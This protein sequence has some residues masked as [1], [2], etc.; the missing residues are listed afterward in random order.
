MPIIF[1]FLPVRQKRFERIF[2]IYFLL[3]GLIN[4]IFAKCCLYTVVIIDLLLKN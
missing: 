3:T 2:S 1:D 4:S